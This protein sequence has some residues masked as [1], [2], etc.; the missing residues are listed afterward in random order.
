MRRISCFDQIAQALAAPRAAAHRL[1]DLVG[2]GD[3]DVGHDQELFE[4]LERVDVN[5]ARSLL[6]RVGALDQRLEAFGELLRGARE[7][8]LQLV[9]ETHLVDC[10]GRRCGLKTHRSYRGACE[11]RTRRHDTPLLMTLVC[12]R[13]ISSQT[14]LFG[15]RRPSSTSAICAAIGSSTP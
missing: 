9:E 3:A 2:G 12:R 10:T 8:R 1:D 4:R 11:L 6:R 13:P 14:A 7:S 15:S 5:R